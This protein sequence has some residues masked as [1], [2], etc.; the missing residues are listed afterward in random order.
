MYCFLAGLWPPIQICGWA[1][2][3][4]I[5]EFTLLIVT[6]QIISKDPKLKLSSWFA[7]YF[8]L[9]LICTIIPMNGWFLERGGTIPFHSV[10]FT[11]MFTNVQFKYSTYKWFNY[12]PLGNREA[13]NNIPPDIH[14]FDQS[15]RKLSRWNKIM[16]IKLEIWS[17][18]FYVIM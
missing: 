16:K 18:T 13:L 11:N 3:Q 12:G 5:F 6:Q 1:H 2:G 15:T 7:R 9:K 17:F 4:K 14:K 8:S 10:L